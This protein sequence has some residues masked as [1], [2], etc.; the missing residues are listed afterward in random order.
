MQERMEREKA[1]SSECS[2]PSAARLGFQ[3]RLCRK[4]VGLLWVSLSAAL[5]C[6]APTA[7]A[8]PQAGAHGQNESSEA[9]ERVTGNP[10]VGREIFYPPYTFS[11]QARRRLEQRHSPDAALIA[12][13]ADTPQAKWFGEWSG[14]I[15]TV[16]DNFTKSASKQDKLALMVV[17]NIPDRDCGQYSKGGASGE[18]SYRAW[19]DGVARGIGSGRRA[20]VILEP[21]ALGHLEACLSEEDQKKRLGLLKYAVHT[22][23]ALP[24]VSVYLDA[25]HSRW[26]PADEMATRLRAAGIE[27]ARGFSL[28]TSNYIGDEEL[29]AYGNQLASLLGDDVHFVVDSSRNGNGPAPGDQWCN[30]EGRALGRRPEVASGGGALDAYVWAK[31]PGESDGECNGGPPAGQWFEERALEMARNAQ[32]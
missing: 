15:E 4:G 12:K 9:I 27:E 23:A 26:I 22:L 19:I 18:V 10:F 8:P 31:A 3:Q 13:I 30:P 16:V 17:Y 21:D 28:N 7:N 32:W 2:E 6:R 24:G 25:G 1:S 5:A 11:D 14:P 29:V 20:V